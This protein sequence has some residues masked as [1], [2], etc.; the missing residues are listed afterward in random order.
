MLVDA[1]PQKVFEKPDAGVFVG[2]LVDLIYQDNVPTQSYGLK[3]KVTFKWLLNAKDKEGNYYTVIRKVNRTMGQ[4]SD[5]YKLVQELLG[6]AP[7]VPFD[8]E[9]LIGTCRNL[10]ITRSPGIDR[11]TGKPTE[12][13]NIVS[14]FALKPDQAAF[15]IPTTFTRAKDK[16]RA[17]QGIAPAQTSAPAQAA[18]AAITAAPGAVPGAPGVDDQGEE[19]LF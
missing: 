12:Y 4:G 11:R 16:T 7:P 9:T 2:V 3:N 10:V 1:P 17:P 15:P 14:T 13:A 8:V 5:L 18:P 6:T 19:V